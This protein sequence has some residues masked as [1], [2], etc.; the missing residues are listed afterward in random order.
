MKKKNQKVKLKRGAWFIK[1]RGSY[2][3]QSW[4]GW[5][6][7]IPFVAYLVLSFGAVFRL[8]DSLLVMVY[9][10]VPAWVAAGVIMTWI[11]QRKS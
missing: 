6:T 1:I 5:L 8:T 7:Y 3:P 11:A 10:L 9:L 4:Q 2:L